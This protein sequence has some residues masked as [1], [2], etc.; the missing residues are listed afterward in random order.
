MATLPFERETATL[1]QSV[2]SEIGAQIK[3]STRISGLKTR[4]RETLSRKGSAAEV[5]KR[6]KQRSPVLVAAATMVDSCG[7]K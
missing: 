5:T 6:K 7:A 4:V 2:W 3:E 1:E